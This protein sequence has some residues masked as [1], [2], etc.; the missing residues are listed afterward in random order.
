LYRQLAQEK[1]QFASSAAMSSLYSDALNPAEVADLHRKLFAALGQGARAP[2][3]FHRAPWPGR[4]LRLGIVSPDFHHQHPVNLFMQPI[5][6]EL[7]KN[8][9]EV[10]IYFTGSSHDEQTRLATSRVDHWVEAG[11]LN[12]IQLAKRIDKDGIDLLLDLAGHTGQQRM[13]LFAKRAAPVQATY[14]GYPGSTGVPHMDWM[15]GDAVVTPPELDALC[16]EQVARLPNLVFCYAPEVD[17]PLPHYGEAHAT[18]ILTFGS[19][20]NVP[21]LTPRT[22]KLWGRILDAIPNSRLLLKAPSFSDARAVSLFRERLMALGVDAERLEFRGPTGLSDMMA[23]YEDV[24]IALDP[25]P[26]N[27]GTTS[28]QAMWMGVPVLTLQGGHFVSRMGASFMNA[29]ELP[30]WVAKSD[31][32]YVEIAVRMASNRPALLQLKR[33]LR[34]RLMQQPGWDIQAHTRALEAAI[35]RMVQSRLD[36]PPFAG[37]I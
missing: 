14:L 9:F 17:Y 1:P 7:D 32:E 30:E 37:S 13:S 5:L 21:K 18:R 25:V 11:A 27:G 12:D 10:F 4:R 34:N 2:N 15:I 31:D 3:S 35:E 24:D 29:A 28:L 20:N 23:E 19:F 8:R 6:R 36:R 33:N 26:Y 16:S 22:L